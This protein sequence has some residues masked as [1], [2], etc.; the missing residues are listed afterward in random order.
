MFF[1]L[2]ILVNYIYIYL[3]KLINYGCDISSFIGSPPHRQG[4][5]SASTVHP[6]QSQ[7][8]SVS[9]TSRSVEMTSS[10]RGTH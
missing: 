6:S 10:S 9:T 2:K 3:C 4:T 5:G 8:G 7:R 1:W